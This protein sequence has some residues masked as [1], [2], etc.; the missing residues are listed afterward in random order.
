MLKALVRLGP[1]FDPLAGRS[2]RAVFRAATSGP[3]N[4]DT[5]GSRLARARRFGRTDA[6]RQAGAAMPDRRAGGSRPLCRSVLSIL[7]LP[8]VDRP[9][10][11]G[12]DPWGSLTERCYETLYGTHDRPEGPGSP[13]KT[14]PGAKTL[15]RR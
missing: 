14:R 7:P 11:I 8:L 3:A 15:P 9:S 5:R 12:S 2:G 1:V 4:P 10:P 13:R 6:R